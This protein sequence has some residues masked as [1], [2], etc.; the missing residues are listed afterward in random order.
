MVKS[1]QGYICRCIYY[2]YLFWSEGRKAGQ[3]IDALLKRANFHKLMKWLGN[4]NALWSITHSFLLKYWRYYILYHN[5]YTFSDTRAYKKKYGYRLNGMR[6]FF[7]VF[8]VPFYYMFVKNGTELWFVGWVCCPVLSVPST[9]DTL[10]S[11]L[12]YLPHLRAQ[13]DHPEAEEKGPIIPVAEDTLFSG[14]IGI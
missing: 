4:F 10:R 11:V 13:S 2:I 1:L 8:T 6:D 14:N 12:L 9:P 7:R 3:Y 5:P